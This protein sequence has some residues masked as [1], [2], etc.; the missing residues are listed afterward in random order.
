[1]SVLCVYHL[2]CFFILFR[3]YEVEASLHQIMVRYLFFFL[4]FFCFFLR[5]SYIV[6]FSS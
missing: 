1:M 5:E 2:P 6:L 3:I 4:F